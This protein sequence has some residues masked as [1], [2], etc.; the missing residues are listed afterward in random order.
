[1]VQ[2][3]QNKFLNVKNSLEDGTGNK[4]LAKWFRIFSFFFLFFFSSF[5]ENSL[6]DGTG[7]KR[8]KG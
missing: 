7:R 4:E 3:L 5:L 6:E 2:D 1:M 8:K